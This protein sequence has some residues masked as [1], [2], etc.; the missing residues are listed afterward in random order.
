VAVGEVPILRARVEGREIGC[1]VPDADLA[2]EAVG[3]M[4]ELDHL[5]AGNRVCWTRST[6]VCVVVEVGRALRGIL[7]V[8]EAAAPR[9]T[10]SQIPLL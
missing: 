2:N 7:P 3:F 1:L 6:T 4:L 8:C 5:G 9:L 10:E